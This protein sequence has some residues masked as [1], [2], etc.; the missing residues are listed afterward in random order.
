M[1]VVLVVVGYVVEVVVV[2]WVTTRPVLMKI[3]PSNPFKTTAISR[4]YGGLGYTIKQIEGRGGEG[5]STHPYHHRSTKCTRQHTNAII[6]HSP[7]SR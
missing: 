3:I 2:V 5:G 4:L 1:L 6:T 7:P